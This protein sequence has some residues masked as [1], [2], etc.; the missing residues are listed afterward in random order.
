[1]KKELELS[2]KTERRLEMIHAHTKRGNTIREVIK[3]FGVYLDTYYHRY[4]QY[5][6]KGILGL[7]DSKRGSKTP[8]NK[9]SDDVASEV[10][11][12]ANYHP[13]LDAPEL[14]E[15][16]DC[17]SGHKPTVATVQRI[18]QAKGMNRQKGRRSKKTREKVLKEWRRRS[19][20]KPMST[21]TR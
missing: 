1:M 11:E 8:P 2:E 14:L 17:S 16:L 10:I 18:L 5:V 6:E 3:E 4:H 20:K 13:E 12:T 21:R 19:V 15:V 9:T 7:F